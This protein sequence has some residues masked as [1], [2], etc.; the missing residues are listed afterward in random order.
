MRMEKMFSLLF[1]LSV[2]TP[3]MA[4]PE[5]SPS[6]LDKQLA[7]IVKDRKLTGDPT[8]G[9]DI[10]SVKEPIV[11]LGKLLFFSKALSGDKN[12]A[13]AS[14][15]HP[16]LG[17]GDGL[18]L[19]VG[20]EA[21]NPELLGPGREPIDGVYRHPRNSPSVF[22]AFTSR[23][24][25]FRD[26]RIQFLDWLTPE[27]GITTPD[28]PYKEA[29]PDAGDTLLAAQARFPV[30][31]INEMRG[32]HFE[33]GQSNQ[34]VRAHLAARIG[35]VGIGRGEIFNNRWRPYFEA[36]F[37]GAGNQDV[38][39]YAN[40]AKALA[41]YQASMNLTDNPWNRYVKG[42]LNAISTAAK[43]GAIDFLFLPAPPGGEPPTPGPNDRLPLACVACHDTDAFTIA[44]R[45]IPEH[46][47]GFPQ[48]GPGKGGIYQ[49]NPTEDMGL[50]LVEQDD[51]QLHR[52]R[53]RPSSLLNV[54]VTAPYGHAGAYQSLEQVVSHYNDF[55]N[56]LETYFED[57]EW[58]KLPQFKE[59]KD[60]ESLFQNS[61]VDTQQATDILDDEIQRGSPVMALKHRT[62]NEL[63]DV[64]AFLKTLTDPCV[65]DAHCL[66]PWL[67]QPQEGDP[68]GLQL[69]PM[70]KQGVPLYLSANC[71]EGDTID[72]WQRL[73]NDQGECISGAHHRFRFFVHHNNTT[74]YFSSQGRKGKARLLYHPYEWATFKNAHVKS[75]G[76]GLNQVLVVT[77]NRGWHYLSVV[78]STGY[79]GLQVAASVSRATFEPGERP[80]DIEDNCAISKPHT[81]SMLESGKAIC[82]ADGASYFFIEVAK[83]NSRLDIRTANGSGN[84][85]VYVAGTY[86]PNSE[87]FEFNSLNS[88]N[89]EYLRI[90]A[91]QPGW[92]Y[93]MTNGQHAHGA[94]IQVDRYE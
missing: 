77:V 50:Y 81:F 92:F 54:E 44:L 6:S 66:R 72:S 37:Q 86:F 31:D 85:D 42:E 16:Y 17:G 8:Q 51:E 19:P 7:K 28:V 15:H 41:A 24:S 9:Y 90:D 87:Y 32:P 45:G 4:V 61:V 58:C 59:R 56:R 22:N 26:S 88:G 35:D 27:K 53:F 30:T 84:L 46:L 74:L 82:V 60:C 52:Y 83:P 65:K 49:V 55:H 69:R 20:V 71:T 47:I 93:I 34:A 80:A 23:Y 12:M 67:P 76:K 91:P 18:S 68:D 89:R 79:E 48:I 3:V 57:K 14:C 11:K 94:S 13:C 36:V 70:T 63:A 62:P 38:V 39:T 29:D 21:R 73:R 64:V 75:T 1:S 40:I 33:A 78:S 25:L 43:R 5:I 2:M 10:P